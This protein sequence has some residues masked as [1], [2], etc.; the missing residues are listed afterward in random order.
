M[1]SRW[2]GPRPCPPPGATATPAGSPD[3]A[4]LTQSA[5]APVLLAVFAAAGLDPVS[6]VFAWMAGTA[7]LGMLVLMSLICLAVIV[8]FRRTRADPRPWHT[9]IA[10]LLGLAGLC[11]ALVLT[12]S[13]F[14]L[15]IGG[16]TGL[17]VAIEA[18]LATFF[19]AGVVLAKLRYG[20]ARTTGHPPEPPDP[21]HRELEELA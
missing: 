3:R 1:C 7:T 13:N 18:V 17:A 15:L 20:A 11:G 5:A 8:F 6:E 4:S 14:P 2:G 9:L 16:S 21:A 10:P 19:T 12:V